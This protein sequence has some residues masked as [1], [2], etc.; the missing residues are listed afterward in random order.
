MAVFEG[1]SALL[2]IYAEADQPKTFMKHVIA[3]STLVIVVAIGFGTFSYLTFGNQTE[4]VI[5]MNLPTGDPASITTKVCYFICVMGSYI[6]MIQPVFSLLENYGW[7]KNVTCMSAN[8]KHGLFR[9][10]VVLL[11]IGVSLVLP[12]V[13][14]V[15][16][17]TGSTMGTLIAV[18]MPVMFYNKAYPPKKSSRIGKPDERAWIR[19]LNW[20]VLVIGTATGI[21]GLLDTVSNIQK[22]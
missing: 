16:E 7:Y 13:H 21:K 10:L 17:L 6:I 11:S 18:V 9:I 15:V 5:L 2:N 4:S 8:L 19:K 3:A 20:V 12:N 1:N 14:V 22:L